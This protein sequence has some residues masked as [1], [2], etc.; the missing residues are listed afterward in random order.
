MV[1]VSEISL[2]GVVLNEVCEE[3][4]SCVCALFRVKLGANDVAASDCSCKPTAS[5]G[6]RG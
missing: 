3:L 1:C 2:T 6:K 4:E 5:V